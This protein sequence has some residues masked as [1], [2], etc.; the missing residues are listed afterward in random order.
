M[1]YLRFRTYRTFTLKEVKFKKEKQV[2]YV[3][4][5]CEGS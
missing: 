5:N 4:E 1:N 2:S 3:F